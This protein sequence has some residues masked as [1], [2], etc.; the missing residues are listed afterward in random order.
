MNQRQDSLT[1]QMLDLIPV[2]ID[3]GAYDAA[4]YITQQF[5]PDIIRERRPMESPPAPKTRHLRVVRER[6]TDRES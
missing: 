5:G 6:K 1:Q 3:M 2:A 4:D